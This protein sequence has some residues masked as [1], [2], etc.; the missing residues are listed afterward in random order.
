MSS[1]S[2]CFQLQ[3]DPSLFSVARVLH[4][5]V[6]LGDQVKA[7]SSNKLKSLIEVP[8]VVHKKVHV[9]IFN[10]I[11]LSVH[12]LFLDRVNNFGGTLGDQVKGR[13]PKKLKSLIEVPN[14]VHMKVQVLSFNVILL[15][16]PYLVLRPSYP[17]R[18]NFGRSGKGSFTEKARFVN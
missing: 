4:F 16:T 10:I 2:T 15:S 1:E 8:N 5:G 7:R 14:V 11:L 9:L 17:F 6:T 12:S 18:R 13:S 3:Y